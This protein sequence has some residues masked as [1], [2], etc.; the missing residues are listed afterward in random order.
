MS[1]RTTRDLALYVYGQLAEPRPPTAALEDLLNTMFLA[2]LRAEEGRRITC[3]VSYVNPKDP[4]PDPPERLR[5]PRWRFIP[6]LSPIPFTVG[7]LTKIALAN[8]PSTSALAVYPDQKGALMLYGM[9]DQQGGF[10]SSLNHEGVGGW[11]PPG[12][13]QVQV[14]SPGHLVVS[15]DGALLGELSGDRLIEGAAEIF[16]DKSVISAKLEAGFNR[17]LER[18]ESQI[19]EEGYP[20]RDLVRKEVNDGWKKIIRRILLRSRAF[21]HGGAYLITDSDYSKNITIKYSLKY[22]RLPVLFENYVTSRFI[23]SLVD[24]DINALIDEDE[25]EMEVDQY[26]ESCVSMGASEDADNAL[27]DAIAFVSSLS[28]VDGAVLLDSDFVVHGFGCEIVT[29]GDPHLKVFHTSQKM[30]KK[31]NSLD[32]DPMQFGTRH[33]SMLR[34]CST[35]KAAVGFIVSH[36][37]PVRATTH[38]KN[39]VF[40]WDN[41]KLTR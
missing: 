19:V 30:P 20:L 29:A 35:D 24:E 5:D 10:Q 26:L 3:A 36:D 31:K 27:T 8:D 18:I 37:G 9:F 32:C 22:D 1:G 14:L 7:E 21:G 4:D 33:R 17:R 11:L 39:C 28:R 15:A 38:H 12:I 13:I 34:Y 23:S 41:V 6:F 2:S 16:Q 40:L 25:T